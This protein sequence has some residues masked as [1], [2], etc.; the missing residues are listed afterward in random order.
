MEQFQQLLHSMCTTARVAN[1]YFHAAP[2]M[3]TVYGEL[4]HVGLTRMLDAYDKRIAKLESIKEQLPLYEVEGEKPSAPAF[5][6]RFRDLNIHVQDSSIGQFNMGQV[7]GNIEANLNAVTGPSAEELA[8]MLKSLVEAISAD[9]RLPD[10]AKREAL[11]NIEVLVSAAVQ[12]AGR[13]AI[14][15]VKAVLAATGVLL[16]AAVPK[17]RVRTDR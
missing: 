10:Q 13:R 5:A 11:E 12:P 17:H 6:P 9:D 3:R 2:H 16:A 7:I 15:P 4:P 1:S 14:G 8:Q